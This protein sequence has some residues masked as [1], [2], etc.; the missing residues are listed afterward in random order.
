MNLL[1]NK[2]GL[3]LLPALFFF[4]SCEEPSELGLELNPKGDAISTHYVEIPLETAQV[5]IDSIFSSSNI[6][7][8][9][10]GVITSITPVYIGRNKSE[11][12]GVL[13]ATA[14]SNIGTL[15]SIPPVAASASLDSAFLRLRF[16]SSFFGDELSAAQTLTIYQLQDA[17]EPTSAVDGNL[18]YRYYTN[19][20]EV[21]GEQIGQLTFDTSA[22]VNNTLSIPL[23]DLFASGILDQLKADTTTFSTQAAFNEFIRGLAIVPGEENTFINS[24]S[25]ALS[26][27][28]LYYGGDSARVSFPLIPK[29][30]EEETLLQL[31]AYYHLEADYSG[32]GLENVPMYG[33]NEEFQTTDG[34]LYFRSS[35]GLV[36]KISYAAFRDLITADSLEG[37]RIIINQAILA[38]DSIEANGPFQPLPSA[39]SMN[40]VDGNNS[41]IPVV[42][43]ADLPVSLEMRTF[44]AGQDTLFRYQGDLALALEE[45]ALNAN[46][47]YLQGIV[48]PAGPSSLASFVTEPADI[49]LKVY[50]TIIK[51]D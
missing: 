50:Y 48:Y 17:I 25:P 51:E 21:L 49:T 27:I 35:A 44:I 23:S 40:F 8:N 20:S 11:D 29:E 43:R 24:Y 37:Y 45:Y 30:M 18:A 22:V 42:T 14:Y 34:Q 7:R 39:L 19:D 13:T 1:A 4:F 33:Y 26:K 15:D 31:P 28:D 3:A 12:F 38:I 41:P 46:D 5:H 36:P 6:I 10:A 16:G 32:T 47:H 9:N 2:K